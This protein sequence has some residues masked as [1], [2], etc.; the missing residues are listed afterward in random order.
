MPA[1]MPITNAPGMPT[2]PAAG[3]IATSTATAPD[4]APSI[5]GFLLNTQSPTDYRNPAQA[6]ARSVV[7]N[8]RAGELFASSADP[9]LKPNHPVHSSEAP[10]IVSGRLFGG[11]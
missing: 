9:A 6:W 11:I 1:A 3:V 4:A 7:M 5:D 8:A 2:L 10:I